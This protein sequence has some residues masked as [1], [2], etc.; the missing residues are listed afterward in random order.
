M[1]RRLLSESEYRCWLNKFKQAELDLHNRDKLIAESYSHLEI[2]LELIGATGIEDRLQD[3]VP[4]TIEALRKAGI[5]VWVLTGDKRETAVS[6]AKACKL[7]S[8]TMDIIPLYARSKD[9]TERLLQYY[10]D[11][12]EQFNESTNSPTRQRTA[13]VQENSFNAKTHRG[14]GICAP[15]VSKERA[16]VVDGT[17]LT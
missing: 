7:F 15:L 1:A 8:P 13:E 4:E 16:L 14:S 10:L 3:R 9:S 6:I 11:Q 2:N 17:T 5:V 12:V